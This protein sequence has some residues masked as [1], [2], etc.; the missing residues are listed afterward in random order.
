MV[1]VAEPDCAPF[2]WK[3]LPTLVPEEHEYEI[4]SVI[5][6]SAI[7]GWHEICADGPAAS[8]PEGT[9][10]QPETHAPL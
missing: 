1:V 5:P 8:D 7:C 10:C 4:A 2:V 6:T 3:P 9:H